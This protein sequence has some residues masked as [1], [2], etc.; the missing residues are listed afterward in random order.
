MPTIASS[1]HRS[2][3]GDA[4][5]QELYDQV[6]SAFAEETSPN[7]SKFSPNS[8]FSISRP[9]ETMDHD[10]RCSPHSDEGIN[11][12]ISSRPPHSQPRVPPSPRDN[13]RPLPSPTTYPT[14]PTFGKSPRP[15]PRLPAASPNT[16]PAYPSRMPEPHP[17]APD[18]PLSASTG[19]VKPGAELPRR[20]YIG[21]PFGNGNGSSPSSSDRPPYRGLPSDPR[22][23]YKAQPG[24]RPESNS[25]PDP[26]SP[27]PV[28]AHTRGTGS[29][30]Y[31][32]PI[33]DTSPSLEHV[34]N[35]GAHR[36]WEGIF[37]LMALLGAH[38]KCNRPIDHPA[39]LRPEYLDILQ[40]PT[41]GTTHLVHRHQSTFILR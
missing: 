17:F 1:T 20:Q 18:P 24:L 31:P 9:N 5:L 41:T 16:S 32:M 35:P 8:T 37:L 38:P 39:R 19:A 40:V 27:S 12:H 13:G 6:L 11:S 7:T 21:E 25:R 28:A 2:P 34:L 23:A 10:I 22:P 36:Q 3:P 26:R 30:Q 15:L 33:P 29:A 4:D 14:S